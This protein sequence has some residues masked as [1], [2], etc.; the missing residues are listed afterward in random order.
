[1]RSAAQ[2]SIPTGEYD[3]S[4]IAHTEQRGEVNSI[5]RSQMHPLS[6]V[7]SV[8]K[9]R[10]THYDLSYPLPYPIDSRRK[11]LTHIRGNSALTQRCRH[12]RP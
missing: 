9:E 8:M 1:M 3:L 4:W 5:I 7:T 10:A 11:V 12:C 6:Q 2:V